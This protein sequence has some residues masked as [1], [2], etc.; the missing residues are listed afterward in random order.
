[1]KRN[2]LR[3]GLSEGRQQIGTWINMVHNPAI[4][5]LLKSVGL[6]YARVDMEHAFVSMESMANMALMARALDFP[7]VVRP[8]EG[9]REW[10]TR[11]LD[12]GVWNLQIPQVD[13]AEQAEAV[14]EAARYAPM[15][16]RGMV[17]NLAPHADFEAGPSG[18][19]NAV[20]NEDVHITAMMESSEAFSNI[21]EIASVPGID[22][23]T[24][25][26]ADL[27]QNLGVLGTPDQEKV[28]EE[29]TQRLFEAAKRNGC[30]VAARADSV[31]LVRKRLGEGAE[32]ITYSAEVGVLQAGY[33][34]F[35]SELQAGA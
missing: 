21:D 9:N 24:L 14:V 22:A 2:P 7:I 30:H 28:I 8:P 18:S 19:N 33:A 6:D 13:T 3:K 34:A 4:L 17:G 16:M 25:G 26:P 27:A 1:M 15:G 5:R 11:L 31:D 20:E 35:L 32:L 29:H 12:G 10:I 23:L